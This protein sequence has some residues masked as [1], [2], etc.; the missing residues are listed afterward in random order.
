MFGR[1]GRR[2]LDDA[3]Y[4]VTTR[5][6]PGLMDAA[7]RRIRRINELDWPTLL[8][9]MEQAASTTADTSP[10]EAVRTFNTRLFTKTKIPLGLTQNSSSASSSTS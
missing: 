5:T 1:A 4:I 7:P 6:S 9:V 3:G 2:G 8:R 10:F